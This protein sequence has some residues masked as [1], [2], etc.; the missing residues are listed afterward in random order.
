LDA[1][2]VVAHWEAEQSV[3]PDECIWDVDIVFIWGAT[4]L[5]HFLI[6]KDE[7]LTIYEHKY[8][9]LHVVSA[10]NTLVV[11][12][13]R[14]RSHGANFEHEG[15]SPRELPVKVVDYLNGCDDR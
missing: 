6:S 8:S 11:T 4:L 10:M 13:G 1:Q 15:T 7:I 2:D 14:L 3:V 12:R 9:V 5:E